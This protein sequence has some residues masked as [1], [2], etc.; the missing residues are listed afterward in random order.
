MSENTKSEGVVCGKEITKY[1]V[2]I[3][4]DAD[5]MVSMTLEPREAGKS[6]RMKEL[7]LAKIMGNMTREKYLMI[8]D[9]N[10]E[11]AVHPRLL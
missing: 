2:K 4:E 10:G 7:S 9:G 5:R 1:D 8:P 6:L 3:A 11:I